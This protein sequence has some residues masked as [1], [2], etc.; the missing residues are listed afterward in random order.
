MTRQVTTE[1]SS[2]IDFLIDDTEQERRRISRDL[3]G[4]LAGVLVAAK[5]DLALLARQL[6]PL[7]TEHA[8]HLARVVAALD[9]CLAFG[10][11]LEQQL[12]PG[13]LEHVGLLAA[14]RW[15]MECA[16]QK[17]PWQFDIVLPEQ[18]PAI[19]SA[20]AIALF[21]MHQAALND[22]VARATARVVH[23]EVLVKESKSLEMRITDTGDAAPLSALSAESSNRQLLMR[24]RAERLGG[25]CHV[26]RRSDGVSVTVSLPLT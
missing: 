17:A 24:H 11:N 16:C 13:L 8:Q 23:C 2:L 7:A 18:E 19:A 5:L 21:R 1:E 3:H 12:W 25:T 10:R 20:T 26:D 9:A 14:L 22:I 6:E 4:E 15:Q